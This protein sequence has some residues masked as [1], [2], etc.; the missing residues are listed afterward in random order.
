M[1]RRVTGIT[2]TTKTTPYLVKGERIKASSWTL[3]KEA[4]AHHTA[5]SHKSQTANPVKPG[6]QYT[7]A[8]K[9]VCANTCCAACFLVAK[10]A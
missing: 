8:P 4:A 6:I 5:R 2:F 7:D 3:G 10:N 1:L 9:R